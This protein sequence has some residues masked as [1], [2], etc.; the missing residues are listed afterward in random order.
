MSRSRGTAWLLVAALAVTACGGG[1]QAGADDGVRFVEGERAEPAFPE[2]SLTIDAPA[3]GT[4]LEGDTLE[5]RLSVDGFELAAPTPG[6]DARGLAL[7]DRGQHVHFIVDNQPYR[8]IYD[9]SGPVRVSGLEAGTHVIRAFASRQWHESVKSPDAYA[10]TWF[11]VGDTAGAGEF[12]PDAPLLT[13]SRP[14]GSYSGAGADSVMVDFYLRNVEIGPAAD[15]HSVRLTVDDSL[16]WEITRW[17]PHYVLGLAPGE[18]TFRLELLGPDGSVVPG[19]LNTT[20]RVITI[21]GQGGGG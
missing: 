3:P 13:Y 19:E 8:A 20:E 11:V 1:E 15:Q 21:E 5:A 4:V 16:S 10:A 18:H 9:L 6:A 17:A 7:S 14:K 2:A 12:D